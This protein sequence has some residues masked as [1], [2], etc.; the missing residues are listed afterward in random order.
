MGQHRI[1]EQC[2]M[3]VNESYTPTSNRAD[4]ADH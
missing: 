4:E 2:K 1:K 3:G